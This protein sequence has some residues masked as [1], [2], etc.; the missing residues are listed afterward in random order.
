VKCQIAVA[1]HIIRCTFCSDLI[2]ICDP[3]FVYYGEREGFHMC[4]TCFD[5]LAQDF[6]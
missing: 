4:K 1:A 6:K 2:N 3:C 5:R